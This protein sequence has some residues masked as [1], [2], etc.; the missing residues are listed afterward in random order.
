MQKYLIKIDRISAWVLLLTVIAYAISG[1]GMTKGIIN[2]DFARKMHFD[3]LAIL[4]L[5]AFVIHTSYAIHKALK[6][7]GIWNNFSKAILFVIYLV[8]VTFFIYFGIFY[9]QTSLL[10]SSE[11]RATPQVTQS[12]RA[13]VNSE[14]SVTQTQIATS[15]TSTPRI[16]TLN[17]LQ[18]YNG[19]NG[20]PAYVAVDG[21]VYDF[22][23]VF[24]KGYHAGYS[25][26]KD[27]SVEFHSKHSNSYLSGYLVVGKLQ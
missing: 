20:Q 15:T 24:R 4:T 14:I 19:Q 17:E 5:I 23:S 12:N 6:R 13:V 9:K 11:Q 27:L 8:V 7:W 16:F 1:Y 10:V 3:Y 18:N 22:S 21:L 26:G 25:A 2:P